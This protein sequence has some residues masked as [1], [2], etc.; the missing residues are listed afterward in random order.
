ME[1]LK[2]R[3]Q[4]IL[5]EAHRGAEG[6]APEN[7]WP[8]LEAGLASGADFLE[9]DIQLSQDGIP[10]LHHHYSLPD[11]RLCGAVS[12]AEI[13]TLRSNGLPFPRLSDVLD[14]I[15]SRETC[16]SLDLK[17]GFQPEERLS[18][19]VL[20][21]LQQT[22]THH[23]VMLLAW[24]HV[25]LLKIKQSQPTVTTRALLAGRLTDYRAFLHT[26]QVDAVSL[27]YGIA[28]P[29]DVEQIHAAGAA[30]L[31]GGLWQ[32]DFGAAAQLGVDM[33]SWGNPLEA[34]QA[35]GYL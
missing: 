14:W 25:E 10:F 26:T 7:S 32:P 24:D 23:K 19:A 15:R 33:L 29:A 11:G 27:N 34:R 1:L 13:E 30:T 18:R 6:L 9:V 28:R 31:L 4:R 21:A 8:A 16:L 17:C 5:I 22:G 3:T 20:A 2:S 35:L 12:W